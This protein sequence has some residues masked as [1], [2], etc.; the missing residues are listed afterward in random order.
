MQQGGKGCV[1]VSTAVSIPW[2]SDK[3]GYKQLMMMLVQDYPKMFRR[4]DL[5]ICR[6][7][8][9]TAHGS[10]RSLMKTPAGPSLIGSSFRIVGSITME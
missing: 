3:T 4:T 5:N 8:I 9:G 10:K 1:C 7:L 6:F 2:H